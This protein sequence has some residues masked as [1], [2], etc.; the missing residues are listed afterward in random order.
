MIRSRRDLRIISNT[1][2]SCD[3]SSSGDAINAISI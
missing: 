1:R 3:G 2:V